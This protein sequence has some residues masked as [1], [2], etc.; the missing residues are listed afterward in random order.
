[1]QKLQ[2]V[3]WILMQIIKKLSRCYDT[4]LLE[5]SQIIAVTNCAFYQ[6]FTLHKVIEESYGYFETLKGPSNIMQNHKGV[7]C[8]LTYTWWHSKWST[9]IH[10]APNFP[11][12]QLAGNCIWGPETPHY[13]IILQSESLLIGKVF[14]RT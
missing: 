6:F 8:N 2:R 13:S 9:V 4:A 1:M 14:W 5:R 3:K 7:I 12:C 10:K 11:S